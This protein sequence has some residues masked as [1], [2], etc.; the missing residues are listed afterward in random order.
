MILR[1]PDL[2][3]SGLWEALC[4]F[5]SVPTHTAAADG[6]IPAMS[7]LIWSPLDGTHH[8]DLLNRT[9]SR[10]GDPLRSA[11]HNTAH[12]TLRPEGQHGRTI[13]TLGYLHHG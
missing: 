3:V 2:A 1:R 4:S 10:P 9:Q 5:V 12:S 6:V 8:S 7:V 11:A 13:L